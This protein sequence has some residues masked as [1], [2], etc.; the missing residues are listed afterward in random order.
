M[1]K[2]HVDLILLF[3]WQ[4]LS[5]GVSYIFKANFFVS[6]T[7]FYVLPS[8][9]LSFREPKSIVKTLKFSAV[10]LPILLITDWI[11]VSTGTWYFPTSIFKWR[12]FGVTVFEVVLWLF[13]YIYFVVV[14]YEYFVDRKDY[15]NKHRKLFKYF[16]VATVVLFMLF[17]LSVLLT[18]TFIKVPYIYLIFGVVFCFI[19]IPLIL[20]KFPNLLSKLITVTVFFVTT[21]FLWEIVALKLNQWTFPGHYF[22]GWIEI[23]NVRFPLEELTVWIVFGSVSVVL[24]YEY[25]YDDM[26]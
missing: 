10:G 1:K 17:I 15:P 21:S 18:G 5:A 23:F 26:R 4:I 9:F 13:V 3:V 20:Y 25:F 14:F 8:I 19:P 12:L 2:K 6:T 7:L 24:L 22:V 16:V 11:A